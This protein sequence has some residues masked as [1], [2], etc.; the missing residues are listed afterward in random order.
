MRKVLKKQ[1]VLK[2]M[3]IFIMLVIF[4]G[5]NDDDQNNYHDYH[6][7]YIGVID[8]EV[9]DKFNYGSTY[10][11]D[12]TIELP[13]SC[14]YYYDQY[15]YFY[16]GT[17]RLI[18]P[19]AHVDDGVACTP[20]I[21]TTTFSIPVQVLQ[22]EPYIFKFYQGEDADGQDIFLTIEVPVV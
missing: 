21:R 6:L 13:N 1:N 14:Y 18:Y 16:E 19:I 5:C 7:E 9:P 15:E 4:S 17:S 3:S 12:V 20:D 22:S 10:R 2:F 8:A 11:I